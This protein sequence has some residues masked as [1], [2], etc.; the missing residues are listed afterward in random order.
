MTQ[1]V[2]AEVASRVPSPG[3]PVL[4]GVDGPDGAGKTTFADALAELLA[5]DGRTVVRASV[6]GFHHPRSY[7]HA[8]GRTAA[9][10]WARHFDLVTV[11][12]RLL[13]PWRAGPGSA[14]VTRVHDVATDR[15]VEET[16]AAVPGLGVLVVDGLFLQR[17]ELVGAWDL[18]VYLDVPDELGLVRV[19]ERDGPLDD[20]E[21]YAG[22]QRTYRQQCAPLEHADVVVDNRD[23]AR[24]RLVGR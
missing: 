3:R 16:P 14:Y 8:E 17:P 22:A 4:M 21:R 2:L 12:E 18:V 5:A 6:D 7:R 11:R 9:S 10:V 13:D 19:E 1:A 20:H 15:P 23:L 24:P